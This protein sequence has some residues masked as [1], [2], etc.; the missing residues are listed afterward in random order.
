MFKSVDEQI[1]IISRGALEII[2][3]EELRR[4]L[5]A[6]QRDRRPLIVKVGFDPTSSDLHLGHTVLLEKVRQFQELGHKAIFLIGDYTAMIGDPSGQSQT[7]TL[8]TREVIEKNLKTYLKQASKILITQRRVFDVRRNSEWFSPKGTSKLRINLDDF[9]MLASRCTIS[10]LIERDDFSKR[11]KQNKPISLLEVFYPLLQ[12][13]DSVVLKADVELGGIDQKFNLLLA[14]ELQRDFNQEPQ[15]VIMMP[16]LEGL[17]GVCKMSKS[18]GNYV[19]INEP[20]KEMFGKL[21]SIS[22]NL[23]FRYY[24]LLTSQDLTAIKDKHPKELKERLAFIIV[25]RYHGSKAAEHA[26]DE[27]RRVFSKK[28]IPSDIPEYKLKSEQTILKIMTDSS[29]TKSGNEAR[30]LILQGA[31]SFNRQKVD[32]EGFLIN[33]SGVLKVGSRRFLKITRV[34]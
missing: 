25:E 12:G 9:M 3:E 28:E 33:A 13:Y 1:K 4:K 21:M 7:R 27:F 6:S 18:F 8:L 22:D 31:V 26:L 2:S 30:R 32:R 34:Y 19:G 24:E 15:V 20:P 5:K 23:M 17:D 14:R 11:M 16:L 29:L 10:R